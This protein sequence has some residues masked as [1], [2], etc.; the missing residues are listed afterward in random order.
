MVMPITTYPRSIKNILTLGG[1]ALLTALHYSLSYGLNTFA[2]A[3]N[4]QTNNFVQTL[5]DAPESVQ[6]FVRNELKDTPLENEENIC[7]KINPNS[8]FIISA[9]GSNHIIVAGYEKDDKLTCELEQLIEKQKIN[10]DQATSIALNAYK[11]FVHHEANHLVHE[12]TTHKAVFAE[13]LP[14]IMEGALLIL[15]KSCRKPMP[16]WIKN[17]LKIPSGIAKGFFNLACIAAYSRQFEARAD[18]EV[19]IKDPLV[20][21]NTA[22]V[23]RKLKTLDVPYIFSTHPTDISRAERLE[24]LATQI[25]KEEENS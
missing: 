16:L 4:V 21:Q 19:S 18:K 7:I 3:N 13:T 20:L 24:E 23:F 14:F 8:N 2:V 22:Q 25:N 12:D 9:M 6:N 11:F 5:P 1:T 15:R 17:G 10:P